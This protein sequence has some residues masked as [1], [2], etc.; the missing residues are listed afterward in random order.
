MDYKLLAKNKSSLSYT[1]L[2]LFADTIINFDLDFYDVDNIDKIKVPVNV[3]FSLPKT[4]KNVQLIDYDPSSSSYNTIPKNPFDFELY[5]DNNKVLEGNMYIESYAFNNTIPII[6]IRLVDRIQE[7]FKD[8]ND[9]VFSSMYSD[10]S[11]LTSFDSFLTNSNGTIN[12]EPT[13]EDILFPYIDFCNDVERF[14]YASRQFIQ[15]GPDSEKVG[16]VPAYKVSSF[17]ERF[18][19]EANVGVTSRFLELGNYTSSIPNHNADDLYMLLNTKLVA[20]SRTRTRGFYMVE[21]GYEH[22]INEYTGAEVLGGNSSAKENED[23]PAQTYGWNYNAT[24]YNNPVD[25]EYGLSYLTNEPND[26]TN[27]DRAYFGSH[28]NYTASPF[29]LD[30][31]TGNARNL[32]S[33]SFIDLEIP[34][35]DKG[36]NAYAMLKQIVA[37]SSTAKFNVVC[38]VWK[39]GSPF[40]TFR[41]LNTDNT[42]KE[43]EAVDASVVDLSQESAKNFLG[44]TDVDPQSGATGYPHWERIYIGPTAPRKELFSVLRFSDTE[45]GNFKWEDKEIEIEAGST[46]STSISFDWLEGEL[47]CRTVDTWQVHPTNIYDFHGWLIPDS[48]SALTVVSKKDVAKAIFKADPS[49][50][51]NLYIAFTSNGPHNPYFLDDDVNINWSQTYSDVSAFDTAKEILKRFNLSVVYDQ[52]SSSVLI[53]RLPDIRS[54][55]QDLNI[56]DKVD[57]RQEIIVDVTSRVSKSIEITSSNKGLFFDTYGYNK[58][59]LNEAGTDELKFDLNSR[60]YNNSLCGDVVVDEYEGGYL[61]DNE[62]G[63]TNNEFTKHTDI[64]ITFGYI[65]LP[66]YATN[67]KRA[68]FIDKSF[69]KG[70]I[71][72]TL[73]S[74]IFPRFIG[75]KFNSL[76]LYH[77]DENG[78]TT[79]LYDFFVNN[80]NILYYDKPKVIFTGLINQEYAF[81]IKDSYSKVFI[82]YVNSNGIIIK[83]VSGQLFEKG[84]YGEVEGIIL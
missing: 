39:D 27:V 40:E 15:F 57:D 46:Y 77:F 11:T 43:L 22:F 54:L 31:F 16:F 41:M 64:G 28:M 9:A 67:I 8:L 29:E 78:D 56:T 79:D 32:P 45:V 36:G 74:H 21:G 37:G 23:Y 20:G 35:I 30:L 58:I 34:L 55:N 68:K 51:G 83:S 6:N 4:D 44:Y 42:L 82:S 70:L 3:S 48:V 50:I 63:F 2:D 38:T 60:F 69:Y 7:I 71:Y 66:Q 75:E 12:T 5:V 26:A 13:K 52:K 10:Y 62:I 24:P 14:G 25:N 47:L 73:D 59:V 65:S 18:F 17:I 61:S 19:N 84:I 76:P 1:E 33:N 49:A 53:D 81:D 80:D 72:E